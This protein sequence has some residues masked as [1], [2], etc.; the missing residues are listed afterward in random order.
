MSDSRPF[1]VDL[2]AVTGEDATDLLMGSAPCS[3]ERI[4]QIAVSAAVRF[5][6][7]ES[8]AERRARAAFPDDDSRFI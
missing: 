2:S 5:G 3:V 1:C 8:E 6:V 7:A 4:R